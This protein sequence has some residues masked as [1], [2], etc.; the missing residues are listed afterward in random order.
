MLERIWGKG[1]SPPLLVG[2]GVGTATVEKSME[3][4]QETKTR[5][6]ILFSSP[7]PRHI[8]TKSRTQQD[9]CTICAHISVYARGH[10]EHARL[11]VR[12]GVVL[13][14]GLELV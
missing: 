9:T 11:P 14:L 13:G 4:P 10:S 8:S 1:N 6:T 7:I 2:M 3:V 5:S 12:L